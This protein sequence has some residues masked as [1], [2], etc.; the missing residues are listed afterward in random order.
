MVGWTEQRRRRPAVLKAAERPLGEG[1]QAAAVGREVAV[2]LGPRH[3]LLRLLGRTPERMGPDAHARGRLPPF[4]VEP[5]REPGAGVD[6]LAQVEFPDSLLDLLP[7]ALAFLVEVPA[8]LL[9]QKP[10]LCRQHPDLKRRLRRGGGSVGTGG[11][12]LARRRLGLPDPRVSE[13]QA[14]LPL[15]A[16]H[17]LLDGR[18]YR[19]DL[20]QRACDD[21]AY[22]KELVDELLEHDGPPCQAVSSSCSNCGHQDWANAL[23]SADGGS[24]KWASKSASHTLSHSACE[25]SKSLAGFVRSGTA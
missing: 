7:E 15:D 17:R 6:G 14:E 18:E 25:A 2:P 3:D 21:V 12:R 9:F 4:V 24:P 8:F 1:Q 20:L 22:F 13:C 11:H 5:G 10:D 23:S 19:L 16:V